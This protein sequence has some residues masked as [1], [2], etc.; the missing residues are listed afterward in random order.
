MT[1]DLHFQDQLDQH[2]EAVNE[3]ICSDAAIFILRDGC[4]RE[5]AIEQAKEIAQHQQDSNSD[6][7][8]TIETLDE[9][10]SPLADGVP[11]KQIYALQQ[12][13]MSAFFS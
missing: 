7:T 1:R 8:G 4:S 2:E 9:A 11:K 10:Q 5:A 6:I 12:E 3:G 13:L